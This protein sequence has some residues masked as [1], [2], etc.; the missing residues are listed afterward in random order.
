MS[1]PINQSPVLPLMWP[2]TLAFSLRWFC[3]GQSEFKT[4]LSQACRPFHHQTFAVSAT[5]TS[6]NP[7]RAMTRWDVFDRRAGGVKLCKGVSIEEGRGLRLKCSGCTLA[8]MSSS[9]GGFGTV[10]HRF[11][12]RTT[13][14][15]AHQTS[16]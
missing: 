7:P 15:E 14:Q 9:A 1:Q 12:T 3:H 2:R 8:P 6:P 16:W 11:G 5:R 4:G 13:L 10:Y